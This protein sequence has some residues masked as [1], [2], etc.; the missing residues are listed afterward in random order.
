MK[1]VCLKYIYFTGSNKKKAALNNI[2]PLTWTV[3]LVQIDKEFLEILKTGCRNIK[4]I[5]KIDC[6]NWHTTI[7]Y[8]Y[9]IIWGHIGTWYVICITLSP[10]NTCCWTTQLEN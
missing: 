3:S 4:T 5:P 8:I 10:E 6:N 9:Y 2:K 1:C 7:F